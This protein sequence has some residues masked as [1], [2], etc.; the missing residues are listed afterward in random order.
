MTVRRCLALNEPQKPRRLLEIIVVILSKASRRKSKSFDCVVQ[1]RHVLEVA[2]QNINIQS[3][4]S[5][6]AGS[7]MTDIDNMCPL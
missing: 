4:A 1:A 5:G 3:L 7:R 6:N 2:C